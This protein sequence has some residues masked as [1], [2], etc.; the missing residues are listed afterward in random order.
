VKRIADHRERDLV[1]IGIAGLQH[2][3]VRSERRGQ[4][5]E[6]APDE[7]RATERS[8]VAG[9]DAGRVDVRHERLVDARDECMNAFAR[10][11]LRIV[12]HAEGAVE[13][14]GR[15]RDL[16]A[17]GGVALLG[18]QA[19]LD[20]TDLLDDLRM[21]TAAHRRRTRDARGRPTVAGSTAASRTRRW[22]SGRARRP[23][24]GHA[25]LAAMF[26]RGAEDSTVPNEVP[27]LNLAR[28]EPEG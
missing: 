27:E 4:L 15:E 28:W 2:V 18:P 25:E 17:L 21:G 8:H 3:V 10:S 1:A 14:A 5:R 22:C 11:A 6:P 20:R 24:A 13:F 12:E 23:H 9:H 19:V 16:E 26:A 7:Q